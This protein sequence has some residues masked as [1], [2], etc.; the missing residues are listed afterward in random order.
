MH[1]VLYGDA[2]GNAQRNGPR[3]ETQVRLRDY[4]PVQPMQVM[5]DDIAQYERQNEN[6][7]HL[8]QNHQESL[9]EGYFHA[10]LEH[11]EHQRDEEGR[12]QRGNDGEGGN[13]IDTQ[14]E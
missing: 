7:G 6:H 14:A 12:G 5:T 1:D 13:R 3:V 2:R 10:F 8:L 9:Y 4:P 11:G